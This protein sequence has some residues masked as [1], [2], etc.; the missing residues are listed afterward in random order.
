ML[1][2]RPWS[3]PAACRLAA[4][5]SA[6]QD[7]SVLLLEGHRR[8]ILPIVVLGVLRAVYTPPARA[9]VD[10]LRAIAFWIDEHQPLVELTAI[11]A[12]RPGLHLRRRLRSPQVPEL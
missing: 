2:Q 4:R 8:G 5:A 10:G 3:P 6:K 11:D 9:H 12:L 1:N 7:D